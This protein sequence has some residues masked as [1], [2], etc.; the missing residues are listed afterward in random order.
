VPPPRA[1]TQKPWGR[2]FGVE[3]RFVM[4]VFGMAVHPKD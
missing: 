1:T 2:V 4:R 3:L